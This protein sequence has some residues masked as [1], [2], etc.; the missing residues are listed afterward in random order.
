M[1]LWHKIFICTLVLVIAAVDITAALL[2]SRSY[3]TM[4]EREKQR[5]VTEHGY[6]LAT[7]RSQ[8]LYRRVAGGRIL[9]TEEEILEIAGGITPSGEDN[10]M[11]L[12]RDGQR[13]SGA[14]PC[15]EETAA[16]VLGG[17]AAAEKSRYSFMEIS[18]KTGD[19]RGG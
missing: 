7:L 5:A 9:L 14:L 13:V 15:A 10:D 2:L 6:L 11:A 1:R 12:Y 3:E 18:G 16:G 4:L 19:C 17:D 8:V